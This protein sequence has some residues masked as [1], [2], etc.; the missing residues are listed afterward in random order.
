MTVNSYPEW[1][2]N[3]AFEMNPE[4]HQCF[5]RNFKL[6]FLHQI[7]IKINVQNKFKAHTFEI[8]HIF[9]NLNSDQILKT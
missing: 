6:T 9:T 7:N 5:N 8:I 2:R 3:L 4:N 1:N